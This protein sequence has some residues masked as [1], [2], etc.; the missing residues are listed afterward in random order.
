MQFE[1]KQRKYSYWQKKSPLSPKYAEP[2]KHSIDGYK[3]LSLINSHTNLFFQ[4]LPN[5]H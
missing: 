3:P 4:Q 5:T 2:K 1:E